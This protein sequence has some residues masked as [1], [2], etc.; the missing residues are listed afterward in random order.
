MT[1]GRRRR[2]RR[3]RRH[4]TRASAQWASAP[5]NDC[6]GGT[7]AKRNGL[8]VI[9]ENWPACTGNRRASGRRTRGAT[10]TASTGIAP[11]P[12]STSPW[13]C[14][15]SHSSRSFW[16]YGRWGGY[17]WTSWEICWRRDRTVITTRSRY[18]GSM[19]CI[20]SYTRIWI[21]TRQSSCTFVS[22]NSLYTPLA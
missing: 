4:D 8:I 13:I 16:R 15:G 5:R 6:H 10:W 2:R 20:D 22:I 19:N 21:T 18:R 17:T 9:S 12:G 3:R 1:R 14:P 11:T 7:S